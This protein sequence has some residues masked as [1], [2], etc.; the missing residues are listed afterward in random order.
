[1]RFV[2]AKRREAT[3]LEYR[4]FVLVSN[5]VYMKLH[6]VSK[7]LERWTSRGAIPPRTVRIEADE[8]KTTLAQLDETT[9]MG[10][11]PLKYDQLSAN[12]IA[13]IHKELTAYGEDLAT[14]V[15]EVYAEVDKAT[16][17]M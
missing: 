4:R 6:L 3:E 11:Y 14:Q 1:M 10:K 5:V 15:E 16:L 8:L 9:R 2:V 17:E 12:S 7:R 13:V